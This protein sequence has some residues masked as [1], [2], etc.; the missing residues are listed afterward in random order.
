MST[1]KNRVIE[2]Q[3]LELL[4]KS[5]RD[6]SRKEVSEY[7][8]EWERNGNIPRDLWRKLGDQ[9]FLLTEIPEEYGGLGAPLSYSM[10]I[11]EEFSKLGYSA[12]STNLSVHDIITAQYILNYGTE[13]Q[14]SHYLKGM[15]SGELVAAFAMTEPGAGSDLQGIKTTAVYDET[16]KAYK[17]NGQKTFISNGQHCDFVIVVAKTDQTVK[18]SRGTSLFFVDVS[19]EGFSRGKNLEKIGLHACDTS[20]MYF[21]DVW[22]GEDKLLGNLNEGFKILMSEL[23]R[24]R[25]TISVNAVAAMEGVLEQTIRYV[26]EREV[27]GKPLSEFQNTRFVIADLQTKT[28][29]HRSFVKECM[30]MMMD[31]TL[32]TATASMAKLSCTEAQG[33]VADKCLQLFGGYGYMK[34]YP[35]ARA[36]TDARVQRIY[37]GTSEIM[38][39]IIGKDIFKE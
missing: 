30:D 35:V 25:L 14:K 21:E 37:G 20:E 32:D 13:A 10:A 28:R 19:S 38:K 12:I 26:Q 18:P 16:K 1:L 31:G 2:K 5:V 24:E 27:F 15:A 22:V 11:V 8:D 33:E 9:G 17:L 7:Y 6:F 3:E 4:R 39:E 34:E 36:F 23:P 29:V